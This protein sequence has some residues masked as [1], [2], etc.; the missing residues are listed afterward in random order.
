ML[1]L[2]AIAAHC[3][4]RGRSPEMSLIPEYPHGLL[5]KITPGK[6]AE[7]IRPARSGGISG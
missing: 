4:I 1:L 6:V 3:K 5:V 2:A 7:K